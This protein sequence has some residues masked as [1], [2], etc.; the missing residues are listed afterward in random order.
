MNAEPIT[1]FS[2]A[3]AATAVERH[4]EAWYAL[5]G[6]TPGGELHRDED[7]TWILTTGAWL[8][9]GVAP[10]FTNKTVERRLSALGLDVMAVD[11]CAAANA[12]DPTRLACA[13]LDFDLGDGYGSEVAAR[14]R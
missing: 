2:P 14:L 1:P 9:G 8:N 7:L 5:L 6:Q 11:S 4:Y 10:R 13:L 12:A 3:E